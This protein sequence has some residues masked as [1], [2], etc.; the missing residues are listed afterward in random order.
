MN[1]SLEVGIL[2]V[3]KTEVQQQ[4]TF[5]KNAREASEAENA[6]L[7]AQVG[8]LEL[9]K[10]KLKD[11]ESGEQ[12]ATHTAEMA[13]LQQLSRTSTAQNVQLGQHIT[14]LNAE[15]AQLQQDLAFQRHA[16][17]GVQDELNQVAEDKDDMEARVNAAEA[18]AES[19][20]A[21]SIAARA[22]VQRLYGSMAKD[23][24]ELT[25]KYTAEEE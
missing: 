9:E 24:H 3:E 18:L 14:R 2:I 1:A 19:W 4:L 11:S 8:A 10:T 13:E 6:R 15:K 5:E 22:E 17:H 23:L 12:I 20:R 16:Y 25:R 21:K 7:R